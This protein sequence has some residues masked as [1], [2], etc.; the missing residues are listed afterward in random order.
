MD[1]FFFL[2]FKVLFVSIDRKFPTYANRIGIRTSNGQCVEIFPKYNYIALLVDD[3]NW[4]S[5]VELHHKITIVIFF[6]GNERI[7]F[8]VLQLETLLSWPAYKYNEKRIKK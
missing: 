2:L 8:Q 3:P 4:K 1:P 5:C 7:I 6:S